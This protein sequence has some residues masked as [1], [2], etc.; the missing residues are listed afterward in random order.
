L[1]ESEICKSNAMSSMANNVEESKWLRV[2][3]FLKQNG[4]G[5]FLTNLSSQF[6]WL[7]DFTTAKV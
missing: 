1:T 4:Q 7:L 6:D 5:D 2:S 3:I